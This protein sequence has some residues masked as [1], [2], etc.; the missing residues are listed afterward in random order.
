MLLETKIFIAFIVVI[1]FITAGLIYLL[2]KIFNLE[3]KLAEIERDV[4][5]ESED[6]RY[7]IKFERALTDEKI[8]KIDKKISKKSVHKKKSDTTKST[9]KT[10]KK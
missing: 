6:I 1:A 3:E 8:S 7:L 4:F 10:T 9:K 5:E 2:I